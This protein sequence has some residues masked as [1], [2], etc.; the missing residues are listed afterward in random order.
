MTTIKIFHAVSVSLFGL[1][2]A[3]VAHSLQGE[4]RFYWM[5]VC[6]Y[7][8]LWCGLVWDNIWCARLLVVPPLLL[9]LLTGPSVLYNF[10]AFVTGDP[11]YR[12]SPATIIVV[13]TLAFFVTLPS[14]LV[15]ALYWKERQRIFGRPR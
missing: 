3:L 8:L 14:T 13:A 4:A 11:L 15:L 1:Y 2:G 12:D 10:Y 5:F 9:V 7:V 6:V